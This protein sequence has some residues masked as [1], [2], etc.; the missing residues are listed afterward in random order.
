MPNKPV[1]PVEQQLTELSI[2]RRQI[3]K[4]FHG[5]ANPILEDVLTEK[6]IT[7]N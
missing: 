6:Y 4:F 7:I 1:S 3:L 2:K 5:S